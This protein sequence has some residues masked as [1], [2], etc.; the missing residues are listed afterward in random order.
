MSKTSSTI[1][2]LLIMTGAASAQGRP[3]S[4]RMSCAEA[5]GY[6]RAQ[7]AAVLGT[8]GMSYDRFVSSQRFCAPTESTKVAF[9]PTRDTQYCP[10]G[11]TC[12][13]RFTASSD[14]SPK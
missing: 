4:T 9:A 6:I 5:A 14:P 12:F 3:D 8:G 7:G 13:E 1:I 11:Y 10:I 2:A